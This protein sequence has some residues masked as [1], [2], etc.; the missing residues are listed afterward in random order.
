MSASVLN[1]DHADKTLRTQNE[2]LNSD[3]DSLRRENQVNYQK[4]QYRM[5]QVNYLDSVVFILKIFYY[6]LVALFVAMVAMR[7]SKLG[8]LRNAAAVVLMIVYPFLVLYVEAIVFSVIA[9]LASFVSGTVY[10]PAS[11]DG[12]LAQNKVMG[13]GVLMY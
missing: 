4:A 11:L 2:T 13:S 10:R 5:L 3:V 7:Y 6:G 1:R 12:A 9:Y 8:T